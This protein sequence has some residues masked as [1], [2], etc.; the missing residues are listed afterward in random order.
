MKGRSL[1]EANLETIQEVMTFLRA[2][3]STCWLYYKAGHLHRYLDHTKLCEKYIPGSKP[4]TEVE[5]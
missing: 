1:S 3:G 2:N 4:V 5:S